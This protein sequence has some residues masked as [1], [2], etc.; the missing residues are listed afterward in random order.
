MKVCRSAFGRSVMLA[1]LVSVSAPAMAQSEARQTK[2]DA[3]IIVT[4]SRL[5]TNGNNSP[6]AV[7][8]MTAEQIAQ[9]TPSSISD[10]LL[11]MPQFAGSSSQASTQGANNG[12][13]SASSFLNLRSIGPVRNLVL[14]DGTRLA[15]SATNGAVDLNTI[16][17]MLIQRVD[18][19]TGGVSAVYGS[20]AV[21]GVVNFVV[22]KKFKGLKALAQGGVSQ[23]GDNAS[24][25]FGVAWGSNFAQDR[26]HIEASFEYYKSDGIASNKS[27][28]NG[29][30]LYTTT[31][32]GT[33]AS[34]FVLTANSR[35]GTTY[36]FGGR[37]V[38][39]QNA[40]GATIATAFTDT[41]FSSDGVLTPFVHGAAT[42]SA[43]IESGGEGGY[44]D[45]S[46]MA[47]L[48]TK[49]GFLRADYALT[50]ALNVHA[51]GIFSEAN[52]V[53]TYIQPIVGGAGGLATKISASNAFLSPALQ[54]QMAAAG[55][56]TFL[57]RKF[58]MDVPRV[59]QNTTARNIFANIGFDGKLF[60]KL[61][62][63]IDYGHN[64]SRRTDIIQGNG[65][66]GRLWA[67]LDAVVAPASYT[68]SD[69]VTNAQGQRVVC[70]VTLTNPGL[71]P[72][73]L[74]LN[75]FGPTA[76][77]QAA[78][79]YTRGDTRAVLT[80]KLDTVAATIRGALFKLPAGE[81]RFALNGEYRRLSLLGESSNQPTVTTDCTGLRYNCSTAAPV[82]Q[83]RQNVVANSAGSVNAKEVAGEILVPLLADLPL[84]K[85]LNF[86]GAMRYTNYSTS[87]GVTTW[88]TG[89]DWHLSKELSFRGTVSRDIRAP[90]VYELFGPLQYA[91][92]GY[93]DLLTKTLDTTTV[94]S[95]SNAA[96]MPE[97]ANT[98]TIGM[99]Y[100]PEWLPGFS[101]AV[102]YF[103]IK[104]KDAITQIDGTSVAIQTQ[105]INS[106]FTASVCSLY[107]RPISASNST[108][109]NYPTRVYAIP[110]NAARVEAR[111]VDVDVIYRTAGLGG[112]WDFRAMG[113]YQPTYTTVVNVGDPVLNNAGVDGLPKYRLTGFVGYT[114][115][116]LSI[117]SQ[118]TWH[119]STKHSALDSIVYAYPDTPAKAFTDL[120]LT[121]DIATGT[122]VKPQ[123]F[124]SVSNLF[125]TT[126]GIY[127]APAGTPGF[128]PIT[129]NG[130]SPVGRYFT[131]G[132]RVRM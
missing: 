96:L 29:A 54:S 6:S 7:A 47:T 79:A 80:Q 13:F 66:T 14:F 72:G 131:S 56:S 18:V 16:P 95:G 25:R 31:G 119:S 19:V 58:Q 15:P 87:G 130:E 36:T 62:W 97:K 11:K 111:G 27:R 59:V 120:T 123:F 84:I 57:I 108:A 69:Y 105:C 52:S 121:V 50:D 129:T 83:Y 106:N 127:A 109:A 2:T 115:G 68:G 114:R 55:V 74:P 117:Q 77:N 45:S 132:V 125:D 88:K 98:F 38:S 99:V 78:A 21:S 51:Q 24:Q 89:L 94:V 92:T 43:G 26:G 82:P 40:A 93:S 48:T 110:K 3:E 37:V 28:P 101:V 10:G 113:T 116:A 32:L 73:C 49:Q 126:P 103:N 22:D 75:V 34:P 85:S 46:L 44:Y 104:I 64:E 33:A 112:V 63:T 118:T 81:V 4:G 76:E 5:V 71:Y 86:N 107:E 17:Q 60:D 128:G 1:A 67:A 124:I 30:A 102:D 9:T 65:N 20:D 35:L 41:N 70:N 23:Q 61:D 100:K 8:V 90:T 42:G 53:G 39:T 12:A 91:R 122:R